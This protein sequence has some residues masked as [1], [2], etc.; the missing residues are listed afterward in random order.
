VPEARRA[1]SSGQMLLSYQWRNLL[2]LSLMLTASGVVLYF[3][4]Q[5]IYLPLRVPMFHT[6]VGVVAA[7][8]LLRFG[9]GFHPAADPAWLEFTPPAIE[10]L[11]ERAAG[12]GPWRLT[13]LQ[14]EGGHQTLNA[15]IPWLHSLQDVRGYDSII[16][17]QYVEFMTSLE[18][19]G[20]LLF[21]RIAPLYGVESLSSPLLDLLNVRYVVTEGRISNPDYELVYEGE[22][23][24]YEDIDTLPRAF[25]LPH[26]EAVSEA[27]LPARLRTLDP[28]QV[29]LLDTVAVSNP[30]SEW[31]LQPA[32][33]VS[34]TLNTVLVDVVLPGPGWLV[35]A[36]SYFPGWRAYRSD[37][38]DE[39]ASEVEPEILRANGNFRAVW[40]GAGAHRVRFQYA[41]TSLK[42]GLYASLAAI[43]VIS[44]LALYRLRGC[45]S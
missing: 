45:T 2:I 24:V 31:P 26:G 36:D 3:S 38:Q 29:I 13:T 34:Y 28:R 12:G 37:P 6:L 7:A 33:V 15:N 14:V 20:E 41:P 5:P 17:R 19:Q 43:V 4:R 21:N 8:D 35:L 23:R 16:P 44:L 39:V 32:Q 1:F 40:L 25:A 11:K 30:E 9:W 10:F 22:V 18:G 27:D 42:I